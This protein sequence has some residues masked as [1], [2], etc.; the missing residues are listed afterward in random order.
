M[1]IGGDVAIN[2]EISAMFEHDIFSEIL[3]GYF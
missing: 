2:K 1:F 3:G